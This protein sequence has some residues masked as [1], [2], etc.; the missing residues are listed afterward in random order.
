VKS[1]ARRSELGAPARSAWPRR[2]GLALL[3]ALGASGCGRPATR[4]ECDALL[5]K[6][7]ELELRRRDI[8]DQTAIEA[9]IARMKAVRGDDYL[10][11]CVGMRITDKALR[12]AQSADTQAALDACLE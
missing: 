11:K 10:K 1:D 9:Q 4:D 3:L 6:T 7:A 12:C 8:T 5:T 2:T